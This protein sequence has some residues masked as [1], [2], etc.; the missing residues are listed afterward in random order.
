[1]INILEISD[2]EDGTF[3]LTQNL[4][5]LNYVVPK[6][7]Q[8]DFASV[9]TLLH[10]FVQPYGKH[11]KAAVVHDYLYQTLGGPKILSRYQCDRVFLIGLIESKLPAWKSYIMFVAVRLGGWV[12]WNKYK[13]NEI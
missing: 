10:W 8:T 3:T 6:G 5:F 4:K 2:N 12:P 1:M 9:P 13:K 11:S 7:F